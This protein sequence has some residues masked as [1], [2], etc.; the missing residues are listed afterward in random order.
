MQLL[1]EKKKKMRKLIEQR[2]VIVEERYV[3]ARVWAPS[4]RNRTLETFL[5]W[6]GGQGQVAIAT[7]GPTERSRERGRHHEMANGAA[8]LATL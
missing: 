5:M 6:G 8:A 2:K 4:E 7:G 1:N 3:W